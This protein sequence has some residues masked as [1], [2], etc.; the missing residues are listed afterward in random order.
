MF[1]F[2]AIA[3]SGAKAR[4]RVQALDWSQSGPVSFECNDDVFALT[5]LT[6]CRCDAVGYFNL[7]AGCKPL[8][9]EQ[10]LEYLAES[11]HIAQLDQHYLHPD[12]SDYLAGFGPA[13]EQ[14]SD[15]LANIYKVAGFNRLQINRYLKHRNNPAML[16]TRYDADQ[17]ARYRLL[18]DV[19]LTLLKRKPVESVKDS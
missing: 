17:L 2:D 14:L 8:Y 6:G 10:W 19:I 3:P 12:Q 15:L 11:G 4:L 9:L 5:L 1:Q 18:N 16:A 7:L 13:D